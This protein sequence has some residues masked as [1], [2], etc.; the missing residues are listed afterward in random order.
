LQGKTPRFWDYGRYSQIYVANP[1]LSQAVNVGRLLVNPKISF[2]NWFSGVRLPLIDTYVQAGPHPL[3]GGTL[4]VKQVNPR[5]GPA[6]RFIA[7]TADWEKSYF[8]ITLG[9]SGHVF[10]K[11]GKDYWESYYNG[12]AVPLLYKKYRADATMHI[13]PRYATQR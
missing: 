5:L 13:R 1:V 8:T 11:H 2:T 4:T 3:S 7:D 10:A 6:F 12:E 9:Q